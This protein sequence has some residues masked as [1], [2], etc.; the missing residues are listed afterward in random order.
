MEELAANENYQAADGEALTKFA[1]AAVV[2]NPYA[3]RFAED[4]DDIITPLRTWRCHW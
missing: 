2:R 4:L 3:G 1:V